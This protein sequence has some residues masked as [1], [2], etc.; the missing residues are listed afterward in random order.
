MWLQHGRR[1]GMGILYK[2]SDSIDNL[3]GI[4]FIDCFPLTSVVIAI[5]LVAGIIGMATLM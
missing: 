2:I 3:L 4:V 1:P 5:G